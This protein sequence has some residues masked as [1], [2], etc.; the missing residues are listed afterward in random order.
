MLA[1]DISCNLDVH[2]VCPKT[3]FKANHRQI[4]FPATMDCRKANRA[5]DSAEQKQALA[6]STYKICQ[7]GCTE[8]DQVGYIQPAHTWFKSWLVPAE[9]SQILTVYG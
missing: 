5:C 9:P 1:D 7:A 3:G 6:I 2:T 8:V 4:F